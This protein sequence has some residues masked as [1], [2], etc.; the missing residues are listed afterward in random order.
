MKTQTFSSREQQMEAGAFKRKT[1]IAFSVFFAMFIIGG[2]S[3]YFLFNQPKSADNV[4]PAL[5]SVMQ[6]NEQL[7]SRMF[8][9]NRQVKLYKKPEAVPKVRVNGDVGMGADFNQAT[10]KLKVARRPGDTL[11][12]TIDDIKALPKREVIFDFKCVEGW[13][14]VTHW[15]GVRVG[16]FLMKYNLTAQTAMKYMGMVTP[17]GTYY[18]GIDM[19]S[20]LQPQ[21]ILCYEMNGQPLPKIQGAPLRLII[22]V[23]YGIKHLKRIGTIFFSNTKPRDYWAELGYDYYAGL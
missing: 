3:F 11:V 23:K 21:T 16:D 10:W 6:A 17:D 14:Q 20:M 9:V 5:R 8:S 22:P 7:F 1:R 4:Q 15:G 13:D 18:V 19:P 2:I 12:L